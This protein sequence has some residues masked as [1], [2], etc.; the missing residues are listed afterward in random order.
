MKDNRGK[1]GFKDALLDCVAWINAHRKTVIPVSAGFLILIA[2]AIAVS[3]SGRKKTEEVVLNVEN[4]EE[5]DGTKE[6]P[7]PEDPLQED[8]YPEVNALM[9]SYYQALADGNTDT[10]QEISGELE[11]TERL[12][13]EKK[14]EYIDHYENIFCYTKPGPLPD[15]YMVCATYEVK[16]KEYE[17]LVPGMNVLYVHRNEA[18]SYIIDNDQDGWAPNVKQYLQAVSTQDDVVD[19]NNKINVEY[20]EVVTNDKEFG[21]FLTELPEKLKVAIGKELAARENP[22]TENG[23]SENTVSDNST[24]G[25]D[26]TGLVK[27]VKAREVVNVRSSDS[28]NADKLGKVQTD[29]VLE[30]LEKKANGWTRVL[31]EGQEAYIKSEY[32]ED[33][34]EQAEDGTEAEGQGA[35]EQQAE[36]EEEENAGNT[37][38]AQGEK[39][40]LKGLKKGD[41]VTV[42]STVNV[43][44]SESETADRLGVCYQGEQL[45]IIMVQADGWTR[46]KFNGE[47]GFVKSELLQ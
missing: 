46:V 8:A 37:A 33:V 14:S 42:K 10:I 19:L 7:V 26:V 16:F 11:E 21:L 15:S 29:E 38:A 3:V 24:A 22:E 35:Q 30:L 23:V 31:F 45:E 32:L 27:K 1:G 43:R 36:P 2:V 17:S 41:K 20:N 4:V 5:D 9:Y 6:I 28:E 47:T 39:V 44:K 25:T 12:R 34:I 40:D 18:G 13:I